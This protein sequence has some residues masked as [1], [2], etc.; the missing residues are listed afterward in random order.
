MPR[1][2][3][4]KPKSKLNPIFWYKITTDDRAG[5]PLHQLLEQSLHEQRE[6]RKFEKQQLKSNLNSVNP[7]HTQCPSESTSVKTESSTILS[8]SR[9]DAPPVKVRLLLIFV[10]LVAHRIWLGFVQHNKPTSHYV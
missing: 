3:N 2:S 8:N 6:Q 4:R 1:N 5:I 10:T 9:K 7:A